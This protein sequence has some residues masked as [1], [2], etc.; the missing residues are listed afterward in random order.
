MPVKCLR[1]VFL[2]IILGTTQKLAHYYYY[3]QKENCQAEAKLT[4][5]TALLHFLC[6]DSVNH[7]THSLTR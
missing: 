5:P 4:L 2:Y 3:Y 1:V 7:T 6:F